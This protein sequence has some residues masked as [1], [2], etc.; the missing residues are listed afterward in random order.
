MKQRVFR[1]LKA[2]AAFVILVMGVSA[3]VAAQR[4]PPAQQHSRAGLAALLGTAS[5]ATVDDAQLFWEP[6]RGVVLDWLWGRD[7]LFVARGAANALRDV[8]HAQVRVAPNG[9]PLSVVR[10]QNLTQSP[11]AD[12]TG[13]QGRGTV[14]VFATLSG[15]W[16]QSASLLDGTAVHFAGPW[17]KDLP[18]PRPS[19]SLTM[20]L[21]GDR[22][23]L[24]T[25]ETPLLHFN[26]STRTSHVPD[27]PKAAER[28]GDQWRPS[29]GQQPEGSPGIFESTVKLGTLQV[30]LVAFDAGRLSWRLRAGQR[31]P[32]VAGQRPAKYQLDPS[33]HGRALIALN[34]GHATVGTD[35][36]MAFQGMSSLPLRGDRA[37][38]IV[39]EQGELSL[40]RP[41][42]TIELRRS[43]AAVQLPLLIDRGTITASASSR[44]SRLLRA[45]LC[46]LSDGRVLLAL[47]TND[48]S[49][50]LALALQQ[51]GCVDAVQLDRGSHHGA[52]LHRLGTAEVPLAEYQTS[53]L[54]GLDAAN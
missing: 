53:V 30:R 9:H 40:L 10:W 48:S 33:E 16:V 6:S 12:D 23:Q 27:P 1:H 49:D 20:T 22:L 4:P 38:L 7:V 52:F 43:D 46:V 39:P 3:L 14:A 24:S 25:G 51:Q 26:L 50:V 37:T 5:G 41:A 28:L 32:T 13:L 17:R 44:G 47:A 19:A 2:R 31:E 35:Y 29:D 45:G 15:R 18:L 34:L 42:E 54:F 11:L 21:N 36:G 8:F